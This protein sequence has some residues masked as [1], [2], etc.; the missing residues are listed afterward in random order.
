MRK[1]YLSFLLL[2]LTTTIFCQGKDSTYKYWMTIGFRPDMGM[3]FNPSYSFSL[4]DYFYKVGYFT[5]DIVLRAEPLLN[6]VSISIGKRFR[7]KWFEASFFSGPSCV[8]GDK[9]VNPALYTKFITPGLETDVQLLF[10]LANEVGIGVGLYGN[11]NFIKNFGGITINI[12]L[13]NGK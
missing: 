5:Q 3:M 9:G 10:R 6:Y 7:S 4:G 13:G 1:I 8:Y 12:T 11:L 2:F